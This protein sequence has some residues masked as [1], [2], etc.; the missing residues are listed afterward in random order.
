MKKKKLTCI[1]SEEGVKM[2][3]SALIRLGFDSKSN[4]ATSK[5]LSRSTVTKFFNRQPIQLDSFKRICDQLKLNWEDII[6][7]LPNGNV[8]NNPIESQVISTSNLETEQDSM[9][10]TNRQILVI[11]RENHEIKAEIT[12][13]GDIGSVQSD[14]LFW[15]CILSEKYPNSKIKVIAIKPGSIK[16]VIKASQEDIDMLLSDFE[17]KKLTEINGYPIENIQI[18]REATEDDESSEQKWR[19]VEEICSNQVKGRD[20]H[21]VDL[22]DADFSGAYLVNANLKGADLSNADLRGADLSSADLSSADLSDADL[23]RAKVQNARFGYNPGIS[24]ETKQG[25]IKLGAIFKDSPAISFPING[26]RHDDVGGGHMNTSFTINSNGNLY[27]TTR[28]WTNVKMEGF[29]GG[30]FIA[31]TDEEGFTIWTTE[32][33]CYGVDGTWIGRS[34]RTELW[35]ATVPPDIL[36]R[37]R[38]YAIVQRHT[39]NP[40]L[41]EFLNSQEGQKAI[42][43]A[44][45]IVR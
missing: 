25:L 34:D 23:N 20:L 2:A 8:P 42:Q 3:E 37:T 11:D 28:T 35:Q 16:I 43:A 5:L 15:H 39:P 12:L 33:H 14:L 6:E 32:Q 41:L 13:E 17:S 21:G 1:G 4:F 10:A 38:G 22:S 24:E 30:V 40:R 26:E 19:L 45:E 29:T 31:L 7:L 27:A 36:T 9:Q 18:L 44:L